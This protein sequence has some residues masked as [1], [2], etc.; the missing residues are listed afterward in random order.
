MVVLVCVSVSGA[1]ASSHSTRGCDIEQDTIA[2]IEGGTRWVCDSELVEL[3]KALGRPLAE[4]FPARVQ[5]VVRG[6]K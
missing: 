4:L 1:C 5:A 6:R 2:E 3:A